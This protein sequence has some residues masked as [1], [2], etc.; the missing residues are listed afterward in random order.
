MATLFS[1]HDGSPLNLWE[2]CSLQSFP[3]FGHELTL[4]SYSQ[5]DVP[6]GVRIAP[7]GDII[8]HQ[9]FLDFIAL[10][11]N[12]FAQF[13][14]WFRYELLYQHGNWW[15]DTDVVCSTASL[16]D[17]EIV[18]GRAIDDDWLNNGVT[19]FPARHPFLAEAVAYCESH[20][21]EVGSSHRSLFGP[22]LM[23]ELDDKYSI[24]EWAKDSRLFSPLRGRRVWRFG[25]PAARDE[26]ACASTK[27]P[28]IHW[29]QWRFRAADLRRDLLP[30]KGSFLAEIFLQ[31]GGQGHAHL[32]IETY[33]KVAASKKDK[34]QS[35][36]SLPKRRPKWLRTLIRSASRLSPPPAR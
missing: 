7:A 2:R 22:I 14:D 5:L 4:F 12:Q 35:M 29:W 26:V 9:K 15:V 32:D 1:F 28:V 11:P 17:D 24:S 25:D 27:C 36:H 31:H 19:K 10:A 33:R 21:R 34:S 23:A 18:I 13:S 6:S 30:P 20:W 16:P 8:P 3:D